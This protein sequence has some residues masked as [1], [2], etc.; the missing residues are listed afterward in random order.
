MIDCLIL[1]K[2]FIDFISVWQEYRD[3]V[4]DFAF[5]IAINRIYSQITATRTSSK[6]FVLTD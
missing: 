5:D 2:R 4:H 6:V 1:N 3:I